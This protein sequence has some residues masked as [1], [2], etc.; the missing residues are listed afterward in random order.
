MSATL[1]FISSLTELTIYAKLFHWQ[2]NSYAKHKAS[3]FLLDKIQDHLDK[4]TETYIGTLPQKPAID[5]DIRITDV[6]TEN[7]LMLILDTILAYQDHADFDSSIKNIID[8]IFNIVKQ[9]KYL[10]QL[11]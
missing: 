8:D 6:V 1:N 11:Q 4:L 9:T 3:D 2:T 5:I 7:Q 10:F